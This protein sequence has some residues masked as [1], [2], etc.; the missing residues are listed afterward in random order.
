MINPSV[1][2]PNTAGEINIEVSQL[3]WELT[4]SNW[5]FYLQHLQPEQSPLP[6]SGRRDKDV[7]YD[8]VEVKE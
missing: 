7:A 1:P 8:V 3:D 6:G 4:R 5:R 2:P